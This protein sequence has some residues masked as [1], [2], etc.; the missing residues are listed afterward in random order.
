MLM[1]LSANAIEQDPCE[2]L[3]SQVD[4]MTVTSEDLDHYA[5]MVYEPALEML[6]AKY[7]DRNAKEFHSSIIRKQPIDKIWLA[8]VGQFF[9]RKTEMPMEFPLVFSQHMEAVSKGPSQSKEA[10]R[11]TI[12]WRSLRDYGRD[13]LYK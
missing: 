5:D 2:S 13:E 3:V 8:Q 4:D 12:L 9:R 7:M 1:G 11:Q 10:I 6:K